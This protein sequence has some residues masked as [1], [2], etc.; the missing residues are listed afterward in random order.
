[1]G[2]GRCSTLE[3]MR[4]KGG[5]MKANQIE[6]KERRCEKNLRC[7]DKKKIIKMESRPEKTTKKYRT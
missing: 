1:M 5:N 3:E 4:W 2:G 7:E 6:R